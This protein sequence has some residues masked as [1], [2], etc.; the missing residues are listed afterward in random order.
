MFYRKHDGAAATIGDRCPYR[1]APVHMEKLQAN[2]ANG[3]NAEQR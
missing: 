2:A 3:A 1:F